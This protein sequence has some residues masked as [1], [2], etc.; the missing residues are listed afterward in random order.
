MFGENKPLIMKKLYFLLFILTVY[1]KQATS[2]TDLEAKAPTLQIG[3]DGFSFAKGTLDAQL[4]M[5]IV[6]EKQKEVKTKLIQNTFLA[7]VE[8][9]GGTIYSY[10]DNVVRELVMEKDQ[11]VRTKK[12]MENTVNLVFVTTFLDYYLNNLSG[13][14]KTQFVELCK[15]MGFIKV[16]DS[17]KITLKELLKQIVDY[18]RDNDDVFSDSEAVKFLALLIDMASEAVRH[19]EKLKQLGLMQISYSE[20]YQYKNEYLRL[21]ED[22]VTDPATGLSSKQLKKLPTKYQNLIKDYERSAIDSVK[23]EKTEKVYKDMCN[24]LAVITNHIGQIKYLVDEL[25]YRKNDID[26]FE[27]VGMIKTESSFIKDNLFVNIKKEFD[28]IIKKLGNM[29]YRNA[30]TFRIDSTL[31]NDKVTLAKISLYINKAES[32]IK[33][34]TGKFNSAILSDI[35]FSINNEFIPELEKQSYR[36]ED[37]IKLIDSL[38]IV[39]NLISNQIRSSSDF[40]LN[41]DKAEKFIL[42]ASKLYQFNNAKTISEYLNLLSEVTEIMPDDKIKNA[43]GTVVSFVKDYTIIEKNENNKEVLSFNVESFLVKLQSIKPY[44]MRR[45]QLNL[46]VGM[47]NAF[48]NRDFVMKDS[49]V[50]RNLSFAGEKIGVKYKL[51]DW[52]FWKTRNPGETYKVGCKEY[53]KITPPKEPAISNWHLLAYGSGLLYNL[54]NAKTNKSFNMPLVGVG[55]GLSF[56][57]ALDMNISWGVPIIG[58]QNWNYIK[59][60]SFVNIGFDIPF[61]EY[62]NKL[63][64]KRN[65]NQTQKQLSK[66]IQAK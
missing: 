20:T 3:L 59:T 57:N 9:A 23:I 30:T 26:L 46:T 42:L 21:L 35:L 29:D 40:K 64:E 31:V 27:S 17:Q 62:I 41:F 16:S 58:S 14:S 53:T 66:A 61:T 44:K 32:Y 5:E 12:I 33:S 24:T 1:T 37:I 2:Q 56:Y 11:N 7:K 22:S 51:W 60:H 43:M 39:C 10:T 38:K 50:V 47:N 8:N 6:A 25:T 48:F 63:Q 4:I 65:A 18:K 55:T 45:W 54:T 13:S 19:D 52:N 34:H 49:S 28:T 36:Q 15:N